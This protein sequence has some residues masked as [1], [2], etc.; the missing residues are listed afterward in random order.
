[1]FVLI[2]GVLKSH[3]WMPRSVVPQ[4]TQSRVCVSKPWTEGKKRGALGSTF[5]P[6]NVKLLQICEQ[7]PVVCLPNSSIKASQRSHRSHLALIAL[8]TAERG[9]LDVPVGGPAT[10]AAVSCCLVLHFNPGSAATRLRV[11]GYLCDSRPSTA[12][13]ISSYTTPLS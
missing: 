4:R 5:S 1:M 11:W 8:Q 2:W 10:T 7:I 9:C 12:P 3:F 6:A 13:L